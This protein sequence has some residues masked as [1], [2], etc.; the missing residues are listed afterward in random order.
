M[1]KTNLVR[2][3]RDG[4]QFHY[5]WAARRCLQ[6]LSTA[7]DLV[8]ISIEGPSP[9]EGEA[10]ATAG[11]EVIDIAEYF[12]SESIQK[13]RLVRYMQ[14][15]HST[16][17]STDAWSASGLEKT[18]RGFAKRYQALIQKN[19]ADELRSKLEF[20]FV[21][22]RPIA[23]TLVEAISDAA[24]GA[25]PRHPDEADKLVRFTGFSGNDLAAF[26]RLV[27][28]EDRQ[29]DYWNQRN[30]LSQDVKGYLPDADV[31]GPLKLKELVTRKALSESGKNPTIKKEDVLRA[32]DTD[33]DLLFPAP[34]L[35][36]APIA[37]VERIQEPE[38]FRLINAAT[39]PVVVHASGGVGKTVFAS[40]IAHALPSGSTCILYDCFGNGLYRN[41][42][43]YR[44][45]HKDA[46]VQIANELAARGL[47]HLLIPTSHADAPAYMRAFVHRM[48]QAATLLRHTHPDALLCIVVDAADNAQMAA[49]EIGEARSFVRDLIREKMP[50]N[51]RTVFL[52]RSHRQAHLQ[53]PVEAIRLELKPFERSETSTLLRQRFVSAT[54]RDVDEFHR[55]SSHNP[56]VQALALSRNDSLPNTLRLLGPNPTTVEDTIGSL[57][58]G[59]I[60]K[61]KDSVGAVENSQIDKICAGLA[62]LRPLIP[63][64]ILAK[65]SGVDEGAI[66]SFAIDVGR[67]LLV[68]GDTIQFFDEPAET[69]FRERYKPT[70]QAMKEFIVSLKPLATGSAYVGA[71]LPQLMLE[72]EMF[73]ELVDLALTSS[74]LPETSPLE[75]RD[76]ELQRLQF[77]LKASLR[78]KRYLDAAKLALKAGGET[79]GDDRQRNILQGNTDLAATFLETSLIQEIVSRRIF[80]SGW[81]G[82]HHVYEAAIM[83]YRPELAGDARSRLRLAHEWL[84]NW[85]QL[86]PEE[87]DDEK[88]SDADIVDLTFAHINLHGAAN[89]A[90][91]IG[92]WRPREVSFR[93]GQAVARRLIDHDRFE[94]IEKLASAAETNLCLVLAV[95]IELREVQ[96]VPTAGVTRRAFRLVANRRVKVTD[97]RGWESETSS[98]SAVTAL[99]ETALAQ[100]ICTHK[101]AEEV[102]AR[103]LPREP[104][105]G[106]SSRFSKSRFPTLRAYCLHAALQNRTLELRDVAHAELRAEIDK[107]HPHSTSSSLEEFKQDVGALLPWHRLWAEAL[108]GRITTASLDGELER[109][110]EVSRA[111]SDRYYRED[112]HTSNEIALLWFDVLHK[113]NAAD[114]QAIAKFTQWK[115]GLKRSLFTPTLTA[116]ARLCGQDETTKEAAINFSLEA[117]NLTKNERSDAE[118]KSEGYISA[119]RSI[120]RV[121]K[122]EAEAYFNEAV[123]VASKIGDENLSRWDAV[124]DLADRSVHPERYFPR[125]AYQFSRCAELTYD[126]VA[127]DKHFDWN[128]T[129]EALCGL[130]PSS[131]ITILSRWRDRNFGWSERILP[132]A[133]QCLVERGHLN[134]LDALPLVGFRAQWSYDELLDKALDASAT[135]A[136]REAVAAHLCRYMRF[137]GGNFLK[138]REVLGRRGMAMDGLDDVIASEQRSRD[139][140]KRAEEKSRTY[141]LSPSSTRPERNWDEVFAERDLTTPDGLAQSYAALKQT[142]PPWNHDQ[143][144][145]QT[146]L[147]VSVG[148]EAAFI[149]AIGNTPEFDLYDLRAFVGQVPDGWAGRPAIAHAMAAMLKEFCR[150]YCMDISRNRHYEVLPWR[151]AS[152][153]SGV[154]EAEIVEVVLDAVGQAPDHIGANRLFSLIGLLTT[155]LSEAQALEALEF[156]L[157]L[158]SPIL[159]DSDGDGPWSDDLLPPIDVK[160]SVA[161]FVWAS[162]AAPEGVQRWE[163]S[164]TVLGFVTLGR[165]DV[166]QHLMRLA[167][168]KAAWPFVDAKLPFYSLHSL[169]WLLIGIARAAMEYPN[170]LAPFSN[171]IVDWALNEAHVIIRQLAARAA[172]ALLQHGLL[173]D[174]ERLKDRLIRVNEPTLPVVKSKSLERIR[175]TKT[176]ES[177]VSEEDRYYFGLDMGPYWY[178]SLGRVFALSQEEI[179]AEALKVIRT[180]FGY[181]AKGRWDEDERSKRKL[182]QEDHTYHSHGSYPRA[183]TLHFFHAY[184][185]MMIVAGRLLAS[186]PVHQSADYDEDDRFSDWLQRHDL[187]RADGRWLWDRR[188]P[189]PLESPAWQDRE[190]EDKAGRLITP[191]DFDEALH[192]DGSLNVWGHWT[193]SDSKQEQSVHVASALVSREKSLALLRA[194]GTA[195]D[196]HDYAIPSAGSDMEIDDPEY[197]LQGWIKSHTQSIGLDGQDRWA[198]GI[199]FPAPA[200]ASY[201]I[202]AMKLETDEDG[203]VWR[204]VDQT[205]VMTSQVWGHYD[206]GDRH[207]RSNPE[208]GSRLRVSTEFL[209]KMLAALGRDL[210]IEVQATRKRRPRSYERDTSDDE[211]R[212][213]TKAKLYLLGADGR[214]RTL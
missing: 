130:C 202:E 1:S 161:G 171:Q 5:L 199:S 162:M 100:N 39:A 166:L 63:I 206:E 17:H 90:R 52:C 75:K 81:L 151:M 148:C 138:V 142:E 69:W 79:A 19:S 51:V 133:I 204:D 126:Y 28:L 107:K 47:C 104:P 180:E 119:A 160:T 54:E 89:G 178:A 18:L 34:C 124:L 185:A 23:T 212:I 103:Y 20:W 41:A 93:V 141:S 176:D 66:K 208:L 80:R 82:S 95:I 74:A 43:G 205:V 190:S 203:R 158:F 29:D 71:A 191:A 72:A 45:R 127:R 61:L 157:D 2:P 14:L 169:E 85:S 9:E 140:E 55:L 49:E 60:A 91:E 102:L 83:S 145:R 48:G 188:D 38:L 35:I 165:S 114:S 123:E 184:H 118:A 170:V 187:T 147:R 108:L 152:A 174:T 73:T 194:L 24:A 10:S 117:F 112:F 175:R 56:R 44:H 167:A 57:L 164:H 16:L 154:S 32:L 101:Q 58:E 193:V 67:P 172:L 36:K 37:A 182:Y 92:R 96:R 87:R 211:G 26:L 150:R 198:G 109:T 156:G 197:V 189:K 6:L 98:L 86:S 7:S 132:I 181:K 143:F 110:R 40:R 173:K 195:K 70:A 179:E 13:A 11:E 186:T 84:N 159:E 200:P 115:E 22:N 111:A 209:T 42:S 128:A 59:A 136:E 8:A 207:E 149:A 27:R 131:A 99:V 144:F 121:S 53:P 139:R 177:S 201:I 125:T 25:S 213:P 135:Q 163:G 113:L 116:L 76:V 214:F 12:G 21:T 94:D 129:V 120:L 183:D 46:L 210:I 106:L 97:G 3:S 196:V 62:A 15:K 168:E 65:M 155:K 77:A 134:A 30:I 153:L 64:S 88:L 4:D 137:T 122:S 105:R 146:I 78:S 68:A 50:D 33:V 192:A 31:Y